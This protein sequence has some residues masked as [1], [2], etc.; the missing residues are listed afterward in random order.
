MP[1]EVWDMCYEKLPP[2]FHANA[3]VLWVLMLSRSIIWRRA[4]TLGPRILLLAHPCCWVVL[5]HTGQSSLVSGS[6][7]K[8]LI[9]ELD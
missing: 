5:R 3:E 6:S 4:G 8:G 7:S 2:P 1:G 9:F